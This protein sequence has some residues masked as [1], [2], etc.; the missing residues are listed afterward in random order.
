MSRQGDVPTNIASELELGAG[1]Y[2][3][4]DDISVRLTANGRALVTWEAR[5]DRDGVGWWAPHAAVLGEVP[6]M[7]GA[8]LE[9]A[10]WLTPLLLDG[11]VPAA[12]WA[13]DRDID[14]DG[15][16]HLAVAGAVD[17][18]DPPAPSVQSTLRAGRPSDASSRSASPAARRAWCGP[19]S[20][21]A[22]TRGRCSGWPP[23]AA[24][25][26]S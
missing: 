20:S 19:R 13:D 8:E 5:G 23:P 6:Q 24:A 25:S 11:D 1:L 15:Q 4:T 7:L 22:T 9:D 16:L 3:G 14:A 21:A 12:V 2:G 18:P 17:A 10:A 26:W